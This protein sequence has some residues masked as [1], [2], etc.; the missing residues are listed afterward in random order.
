MKH[1]E[2]KWPS[3]KGKVLDGFSNDGWVNEAIVMEIQKEG[4]GKT[5]RNDTTSHKCRTEK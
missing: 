2:V 4:Q 3:R 5:P 1:I